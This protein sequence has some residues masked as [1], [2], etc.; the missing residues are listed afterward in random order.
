MASLDKT[1]V[2]DEVSRLKAG[3][4]TLYS[5][6]K[7]SVNSKALMN[8]LFMIVELMLSIFLFQPICSVLC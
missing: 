2:R 7:I 6:G 1:S 8:S 4:E 3:F 5:D